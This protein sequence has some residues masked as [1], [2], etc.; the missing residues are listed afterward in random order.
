MRQIIFMLVLCG[1][2]IG[3]DEPTRSTS[4]AVDGLPNLQRVDPDLDVWVG[5]QPHPGIGDAAL[6]RLGIRSM[7]VVDALPPLVGEGPEVVAHLPLKYSG[8]GPTESSQ[9]AFLLGSLE[10][11]IY[12]HCHHGTNRAPAAAAIGLIATGE[13]TNEQGLALLEQSGTS[14]AFSGLFESVRSASVLPPAQRLPP[15][16]AGARIDDLALSMAAV[17]DAYLALE[18]ASMQGWTDPGAAAEAAR[19]VD[20][21]R[22]CFDTTS[23]NEDRVFRTLAT[24]SIERAGALESSLVDGD[25]DGAV[26]QLMA[27]A[28]TCSACH[29]RFRN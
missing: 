20:L 14:A 27:V 22:T 12:I 15:G 17:E 2:V 18:A 7:L 23:M 29:D 6:A 4:G 24:G 5:G 26:K 3:C 13:W 25:R 1:L 9:L 10:R 8:I 11:P 16:D 19:L 21:L 28:A